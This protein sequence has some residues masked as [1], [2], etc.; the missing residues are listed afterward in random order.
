MGKKRKW[1]AWTLCEEDIWL[2]AK[3]MG[4]RQLTE[5]QVE[6]IARGFIKGFEWA[7]DDWGCVME[8]AIREVVGDANGTE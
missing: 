4:I 2:L 8:E 7:N 6:D 3:D 5:E 1:V